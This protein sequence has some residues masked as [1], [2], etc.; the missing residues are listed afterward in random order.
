MVL[1]ITTAVRTSNPTS[2]GWE[3]PLLTAVDTV[4]RCVLCIFHYE[5]FYSF[6]TDLIKELKKLRTTLV[7]MATGFWKWH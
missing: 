1:F 6:R 7:A 3:V 4:P 2:K 5:F